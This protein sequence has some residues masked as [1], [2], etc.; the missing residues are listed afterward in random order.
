MISAIRSSDPRRFWVISRV[1]RSWKA[2]SVDTVMSPASISFWMPRTSR[3][4][5]G[6]TIMES[7]SPLGSSSK[8]TRLSPRRSWQVI[9]FIVL[10]AM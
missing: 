7:G 9:L 8:S 3:A 1:I 10:L 6:I 5:L 2:S 4:S